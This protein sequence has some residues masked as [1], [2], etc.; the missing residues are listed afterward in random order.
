MPLLFF[1]MLPAEF[2]QRF[3]Q[4]CPSHL[5]AAAWDS[6]EQPKWTS[7]RVNR[8]KADEDSV[9][10]DLRTAGLQLDAVDWARDEGI[11][12]WQVPPEQR[13]A[14]THSA[15]AESGDIYIQSQSSMLAPLLLA[16]RPCERVLDLAAAPGGKTV[17]LAELM[18]NEGAISA[19]EPVKGRFFRLKANLERAGVSNTRAYLKDG[20]AVGSLKPATFD[21]VLLDAPCSSESR[22]RA[23]DPA[24]YRHWTP[25]KVSECARKQ[26]RLILSAFDALKAGG[27]LLYCTCSYAPEENE[28]VV[29]HLLRKREGARVRPLNLALDNLTPG[30]TRDSKQRPLPDA[31]ADTLRVWPNSRMDGFFLALVDKG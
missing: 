2:V 27:S 5:K 7:F 29:A 14:L 4:L 25:R 30:L 21:R 24:S 9:C 12:A 22:F 3:D 16:P 11:A 17:L 1:A 18:E 19:V 28:M 13:E 10:R 8:L 23:D 26:K 31:C 15:P 20:R 6:F